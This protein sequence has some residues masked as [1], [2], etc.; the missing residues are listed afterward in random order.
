MKYIKY[1]KKVANKVNYVVYKLWLISYCWANNDAIF[2]QNNDLEDVDHL[3]RTRK[4]Q[5][6]NVKKKAKELW[7]K[8]EKLMFMI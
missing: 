7:M 2:F 6:G 4:E 8:I 5:W 3:M 1:R